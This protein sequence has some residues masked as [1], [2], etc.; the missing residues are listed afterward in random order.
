MASTGDRVVV[1]GAG[2]GGLAAA[3]RLAAAGLDVTVIEAAAGPGGKMRTLPSPAGPVDAGPTVLTMRPVFEALFAA[4]GARLD[5]HLTL[6]PQPILAR[7]WWEDGSRLDLFPD[8]EHSAAAIADFAGPREADRFRAF[9][10]ATAR[11]FDAF[12][13]PVMRAP[14]PSLPGIAAAALRAPGLWPWLVPWATLAGRLAATFEDPRLRQLFGRYATYVGG[15]PHRVPAVLALVWQSE[16]RGVWAVQGGM[17]AL[18]QALATLAAQ[19]GARIRYGC[20]AEA[21][22]TA[23]GRVSAVRLAGGARIAADLVVFNGDPRALATGLMGAA[24]QGAVRARR[25]APRALSAWVWSFAAEARG[26]PLV[27]HNVFFT[28]D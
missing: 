19:S 27:H 10:A 1:I 23:G 22:E 28:D 20:P 3:I 13:A 25:T 11:L 9:H 5:D 15:M 16:A 17:H 21:I 24:A 8:A 26:L 6:I 12:E 7:H 4:A 14:R 18:A 2:M